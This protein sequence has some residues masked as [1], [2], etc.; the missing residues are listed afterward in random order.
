M[1][2]PKP[3]IPSELL[4]A[5]P[6]PGEGGRSSRSDPTGPPA[7]PDRSV[8]ISPPWQYPTPGAQDFFKTISANVAS[9][10]GTTQEPTELVFTLPAGYDGVVSFV[11]YYV[12]LPD[13]LLRIKWAF[14]INGSPRSGFDNIRCYPRAASNV[15]EDFPGTIRVFQNDRLSIVIT[16]EGTTAYNVNARYGGF[17]WPRE[18]GERLTGLKSGEY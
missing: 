12:D 5:L 7:K 18:E 13:A 17:I 8:Q 10:A 1:T 16:N 3:Y 15:S 14:Q 2:S 9:G 6:T 11:G 4:S